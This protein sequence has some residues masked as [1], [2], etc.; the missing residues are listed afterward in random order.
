MIELSLM[1]SVGLVSVL[2]SAGLFCLLLTWWIKFK[3]VVHLKSARVYMRRTR[4]IFEENNQANLFERQC[5]IVVNWGMGLQ[6]QGMASTPTS[7]I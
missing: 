6:S 2:S 5:S 3:G 4:L 1:K 7:A